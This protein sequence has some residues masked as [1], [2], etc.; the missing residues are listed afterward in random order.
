[1]GFYNSALVKLPILIDPSGSSVDM[2]VWIVVESNLGIICACVPILG[3][4]IKAWAASSTFMRLRGWISSYGRKSGGSSRTFYE[5][6]PAPPFPGK[7]D[8][9]DDKAK[10]YHTVDANSSVERI[11]KLGHMWEL[12]ERVGSTEVKP[13]SSEVSL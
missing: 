13:Q 8:E 10:A 5:S 9:L 11:L 7:F 12:D 2:A 3:P 6:N 1:M 4:C